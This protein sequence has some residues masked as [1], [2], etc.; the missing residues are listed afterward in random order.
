MSR[1]QLSRLAGERVRVVDG[2]AER[3]LDLADLPSYVGDREDGAVRWVWDDT[4]R[5]YPA[6][7]AAGVRVGRCHDLRLC[8]RLLRRAPAVDARLLA[9]LLVND[10]RAARLLRAHGIDEQT[11]REHLDPNGRS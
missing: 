6:L 11:V 4:A 2:G 8:H 5:W 1:V 3:E 9:L 10:T 7:L